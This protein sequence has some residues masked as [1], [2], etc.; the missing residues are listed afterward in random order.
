MTTTT[1]PNASPSLRNA[2][3]DRG[4]AD[5]APDDCDDIIVATED[6]TRPPRD[7]AVCDHCLTG[8]HERV[9]AVVEVF[10]DPGDAFPKW[11][12]MCAECSEQPP[13]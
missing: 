10:G 4:I 13:V 9:P 11:I 6:V 1:Y 12:P 7:G 8:A 2:L 5:L 3:Y